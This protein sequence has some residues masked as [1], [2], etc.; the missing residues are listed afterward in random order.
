MFLNAEILLLLLLLTV[1]HFLKLVYT[2]SSEVPNFLDF[3]AV[4]FVDH[5][6][7]NIK[8]TVPTQVWM[9]QIGIHVIQVLNGWEWDEDSGDITGFGS[10][11]YDGDDI[12]ILD[13]K[14]QRWMLPKPELLKSQHKWN[15]DKWWLEFMEHCLTEDC[16]ERLKS[17]LKYG[18]SSLQK[19]VSTCVPSAEKNPS[20]PVSCHATGFYANRASMF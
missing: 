1:M 19:T 15:N 7:S 10:I 6:D 4:V 16:P 3:V 14:V 13:M 2:A 11:S 18:R 17:A 8:I 9:D 12:L 5:Y 20:S